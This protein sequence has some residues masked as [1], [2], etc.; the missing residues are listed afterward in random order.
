MVDNTIWTHKIADENL[1]KSD[2]STKAIHDSLQVALDDKRVEVH[3][4]SIGDGLTFIR[5]I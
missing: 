1:R 4:I 2:K 3:T 5:K